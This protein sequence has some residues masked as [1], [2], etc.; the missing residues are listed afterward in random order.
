MRRIRLIWPAKGETPHLQGFLLFLKTQ[1]LPHRASV[2]HPC[3]TLLK[4]SFV[5][6][7]C[8]GIKRF[9]GVAAPRTT[10]AG[11]S[12]IPRHGQRNSMSASSPAR[13]DEFGAADLKE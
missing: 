2:H 5:S 8:T 9:A 6:N 7:C 11:A 3:I 10:G 13:K 4:Q 1:N 12:R